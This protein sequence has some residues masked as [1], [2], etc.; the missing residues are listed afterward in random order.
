M[1]A[2]FK[3]IAEGRT[4]DRL[5]HL[6]ALMPPMPEGYQDWAYRDIQWMPR[7]RWVA[8]L[9]VVGRDNVRVLAF[10]QRGQEGRG[11]CWISPA[12]IAALAAAPDGVEQRG[13]TSTPVAQAEGRS[14]GLNHDPIEGGERG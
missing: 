7:S 3:D 9:D 13:S 8:F 1:T 10:S 6:D 14:P 2:T 12:G 5:S 11:Q 4:G